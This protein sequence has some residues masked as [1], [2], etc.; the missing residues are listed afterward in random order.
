MRHCFETTKKLD[1]H[2]MD[3]NEFIEETA[4]TTYFKNIINRMK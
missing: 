1:N 3:K 2:H 4:F